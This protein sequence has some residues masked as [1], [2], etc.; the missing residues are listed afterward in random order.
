MTFKVEVAVMLV[1]VW[2]SAVLFA[3]VL[4]AS[5]PRV[6]FWLGAWF[7]CLF[8]FVWVSG[9]DFTIRKDEK[10]EHNME[11]IFRSQFAGALW[12]VHVR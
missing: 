1:C 6:F 5:C 10:N 3:F 9:H 7:F 2:F 4:F 11:A 12:T 8:F